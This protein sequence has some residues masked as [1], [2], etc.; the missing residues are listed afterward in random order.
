MTIS[1]FLTARRRHWS[2]LSRSAALILLSVKANMTGPAFFGPD[3]ETSGESCPAFPTRFTIPQS[4]RPP[5][6]PPLPS[7]MTEPCRPPPGYC[8]DPEHPQDP[9]VPTLTITSA[10]PSTTPPAYNS[11]T[12]PKYAAIPSST[13]EQTLLLAPPPFYVERDCDETRCRRCRFVSRTPHTCGR[14]SQADW[15]KRL[16]IV[17]NVL[18]WGAVLGG[19]WLEWRSPGAMGR[20]MWGPPS[21]IIGGVWPYCVESPGATGI[22]ASSQGEDCNVGVVLSSC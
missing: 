17:L 2:L 18:V 7:R 22:G 3:V 15:V 6:F 10:T 4:I 21:I 14:S 16:L 19:Y 20:G 5:I 9:S 13:T 8:P 12:P 1:V 11:S